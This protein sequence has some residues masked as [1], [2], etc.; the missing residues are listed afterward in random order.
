A[1]GFMNAKG[2]SDVEGFT[3]AEGSMY[4]EEF[5]DVECSM[6]AKGFLIQ[7]LNVFAERIRLMMFRGR[8]DGNKLVINARI[9]SPL[10][11]LERAERCAFLLGL[12]KILEEHKILGDLISK[13]DLQNCVP[14]PLSYTDRIPFGRDPSVPDWVFVCQPLCSDSDVK[15][16]WRFLRLRSG[17]LGYDVTELK[18]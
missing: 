1:V 17:L 18:E 13:S 7:Y 12:D 8:L 3:Y 9:K 15:L 16:V 11:Q 14:N 6:Y 10:A 2:V 5:M 4:F